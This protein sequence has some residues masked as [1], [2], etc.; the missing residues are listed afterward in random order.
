MAPSD[1]A[2]LLPELTPDEIRAVIELLFRQR[3][4][5]LALR[6]LPNEMLPL[7]Y[8]AL[9]DQRLAAVIGRLEIDDLLEF[10]EFIPEDRRDSVI[11]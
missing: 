1:V 11:E 7:V 9:A 10:V 6:E 3:R 4:A 5:A 2:L 8:D